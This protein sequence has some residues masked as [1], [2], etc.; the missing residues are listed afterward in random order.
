M[1]HYSRFKAL[2]VFAIISLISFSGCAQEQR[3]VLSDASLKGKITH[4]GK[5]VPYALV[6]VMGKGGTSS[7]GNADADGNYTVEHA[8]TGEVKIGVNTEAGKGNMKG[9]MMAAAQGGDKS[10]KPTFVDVPS[11]F[12][13][14]ETSGI[15]ANVTDSKGANTF[16][17]VIK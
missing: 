13:D 8:P 11:K 16:D 14:P 5:L 1:K 10:A 6:I 9:A 12:F 15:K 4:N 17:I 3:L 2:F 7:T